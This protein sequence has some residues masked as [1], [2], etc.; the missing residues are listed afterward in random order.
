MTLDGMRRFAAG[1]L[2]GGM[3]LVERA[4]RIQQ[5]LDDCEGGGVA[6][7]FLAQMTSAQGDQER[8]LALYRDS[9]TL[10]ERV[11]DH[12]EIAR[13]LCEMGWTA[14]GAGNQ[15]DAQDFFRRA[16]LAYEAAG[17]PRGT[18]L[19]MLGLAAVEVARDHAERAVVIAAAADALSQ[20]AGVVVEHPLAPEVYE[21]IEALKGSI[22][23]S[24]LD[25]IVADGSELTPAAVLAM[26]AD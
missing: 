2:E 13:V 15:R 25:G 5:R 7:S 23:R 8:A 14:L 26:I 3:A 1:D 4:R 11:G 20:R 6:L 24:E 19:A 12:P 16:V 21:R 9:L 18:G 22:P 17:S 10:F